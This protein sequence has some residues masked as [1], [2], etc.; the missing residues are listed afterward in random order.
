[1][2]IEVQLS[3]RCVWNRRQLGIRLPEG[4]WYCNTRTP[5][6]ALPDS[7]LHAVQLHHIRLVTWE[8]QDPGLI[9][10]TGWLHHGFFSPMHGWKARC[11]GLV[12]R[13]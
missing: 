8:Q 11:L 10:P 13:I 6:L 2:R 5:S 9:S 12:H 4:E 3:S 1:M 7:S